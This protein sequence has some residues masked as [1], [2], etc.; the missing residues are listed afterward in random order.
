MEDKHIILM[1]GV[2]C[3]ILVL[4]LLNSAFQYNEVALLLENS[5]NS[6]SQNQTFNFKGW[7]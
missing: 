1:F 7:N 6:C 2:L 4:L 3:I 5:I